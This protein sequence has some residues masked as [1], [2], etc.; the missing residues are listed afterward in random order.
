MCINQYVLNCSARVD[1][2]EHIDT[3]NYRRL[4]NMKAASFAVSGTRKVACVVSGGTLWRD[5]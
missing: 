3:M 1:A 4:E 2:G 5:Q